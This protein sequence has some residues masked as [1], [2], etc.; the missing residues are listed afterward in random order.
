M[1]EHPLG[2]GGSDGERGDAAG[3]DEER[4]SRDPFRARQSPS[5]VAGR[6]RSLT[7]GAAALA[8]ARTWA[9]A[10]VAAGSDG[11]RPPSVG[12]VFDLR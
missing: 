3:T 10:I 6:R 8:P 12:E 9:A 7:Q 4:P 1:V 2:N 5:T 11:Q